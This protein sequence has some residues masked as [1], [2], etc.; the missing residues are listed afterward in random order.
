MMN[1]DSVASNPA[2]INESIDRGLSNP[3]AQGTPVQCALEQNGIHQNTGHQEG[4]DQLQRILKRH[5][6][7][8][9]QN[10]LA[11][12][13]VSPPPQSTSISISISNSNSNSTSTIDSTS[14]TT[15]TVHPTLLIYGI[16]NLGR[17]DDGLG[18]RFIEALEELDLHSSIQLDSNYQLNVEDSILISEFETVLF[19]DASAEEPA[20][21]PFGIRQ[22]HP[23][24][25]IAFS[26]HALSFESLLA[27]TEQYYQKKPQAFLLTIPGSN[28]GIADQ[29]TTEALDHLEQTLEI[30]KTKLKEHHLIL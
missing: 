4:P 12:S 27:I 2:P 24:G 29:L 1:K 6:L 3:D 13:M 10:A 8:N 5:S 26:T 17:E 18:I 30:F 20:Q 22:L 7:S 23:S 21:R 15:S 16:G 11:S 28:W 19:V 25:E 9:S 14:P